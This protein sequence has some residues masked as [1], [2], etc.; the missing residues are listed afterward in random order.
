MIKLKSFE[1]F[2]YG[3]GLKDGLNMKPDFRRFSQ[4]IVL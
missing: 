2:F 3:P 1:E 4:N